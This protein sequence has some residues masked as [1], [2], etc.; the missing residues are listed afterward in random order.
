ISGREILADRI[1]EIEMAQLQALFD[2]GKI[3]NVDKVNLEKE[4][5]D[6]LTAVKR[7][8]LEERLDLE[9]QLGALTGDPK[10]IA[11]ASNNLG[12]L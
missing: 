5:Q 6:K 9:M 7:I 3:S 4:L 1:Y 12:A 8:G 11:T 2:A 10:G